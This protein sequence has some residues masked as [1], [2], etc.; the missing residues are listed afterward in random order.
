[1]KRDKIALFVFI[2]AF[3]WEVYRRNG[4]FLENLKRDARKLDTIFGYSSACDPSIITGVTPSEHRMWS[5]FYY[6]PGTCPYRWLRFLRFLPDAI[7]SRGRVRYWMSNLIKRIHGIT[8]YFM[9]YSVPFH[10]L[11]LFEY[12]EMRSIWKEGVAKGTTIFNRLD[13]AGIPYYVHDSG[14]PDESKLAKLRSRIERAEIRFGYVSLGKLDALMH[15]VGNDGP[16]VT[17]LVRWYDER[18]RE[19]IAAAEAAYD[20]VSWYVF[21]DHGMHNTTGSYDLIADIEALGLAYGR[22]YVAF[23]DATMARFWFLR[24]EARTRIEAALRVH[25]KGRIV[26]DDELRALGVFF[27]DHQYG[28][29]VFLMHSATQIVPS[30]MGAKGAKG[31]HGFHPAD[32]DSSASMVTNRTLPADITAIHHIYRLM[33]RDLG[34]D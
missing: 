19:L 14:T 21:T 10:L 13:Q 9:L 7:F 26:P 5:S 2:D 33:T 15:R 27:E 12:A 6:A 16:E 34:L 3:G 22:D 18:I 17:A 24:D 31:L 20:E 30:F 1:M 4:F 23:Y 8:G 28:D 11:P 32:A 29:M 25:P